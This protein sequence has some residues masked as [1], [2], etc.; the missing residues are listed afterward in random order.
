MDINEKAQK[1]VDMI[2]SQMEELSNIVKCASREKDFDAARERLLRWKSRTAR[3]LSKQ[4][5]PDEG[6]K[7]RKKQKGSS[8][9]GRHLHNLADE[10]NRYRG[11]LSSLMEEVEKH[12][13][14]ILSTQPTVDIPS[15]TISREGVFFAG[16][17]FDA[18][19]K[20][21]EILEH[22]DIQI[23]IIDGYVSS[24]VLNLLTRKKSSVIVKILTKSVDSVLKMEAIAFNKQCGKLAI[25][26][27]TAFHD[28][29]I[30]IDN[31]D[32]YHFGASIKDVGK[33]G[34][35]FSRIE[36]GSVIKVLQKKL[37]EE[38]ER[39]TVVI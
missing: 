5:H 6:E 13:K 18:L 12:P 32:F 33:R 1:T 37:D 36:E 16:Q 30:I 11:F 10:A 17:Y 8:L 39:A 7:L 24:D 27:S 38:W 34:F 15:M 29:F 25:R 35:M 2:K 3:L 22:A 28:R 14:D 19:Q 4:I 31:K 20:V 21:R 9:I 23:Y 26:T